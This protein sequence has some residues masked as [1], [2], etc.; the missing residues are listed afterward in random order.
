MSQQSH[1]LDLFERASSARAVAHSLA[2]PRAVKKG[3]ESPFADGK[4]PW[5]RVET[6]S[7][8]AQFDEIQRALAP[9]LRHVAADA[10]V[11]DGDSLAL[12]R[13]LPAHSVSLILDD[14]PYHATKKGNIHGD[15]A[16]DTDQ[17]YLDWMAQYAIE[18]RR[19]LK[20]NG[21]LFCFCDSSMAARLEVLFSSHFNV[22]SHVVWTK[23]N[24]PGFDGWKG[25]MK[26]EALRQWYPHSERIL[27]AEPAVDGNLGRSPFAQFLREVRLQSG[28]SQHLLTE[29]IGAYGKVNHGG[30]VSNWETGRNTPSREQ[31]ERMCAAFI[32]TG[33]I[34]FE[35][36]QY[37]DAV[38]VFNMDASKEFTDIWTF[39]SVRPYKGKHPAEKPAALLEHAIEA[40][41]RPGDIVLDCHAGSG[42]TAIAALALKRRT[43]AMEIDPRWASSIAKWIHALKR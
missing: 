40:T 8:E 18:W 14:P 15:T 36:P 28:L 9:H 22:L 3:A 17:Q 33:N 34:D 1:D 32:G 20:T 6:G 2:A 38:R 7:R 39:P 29:L 19:V 24:D 12:L 30:A 16:F 27:F 35:L 37:E 42:S 10:L 13:R 21:S 11:A 43:I 26:K 25:K 4:L 23:P 5:Y 41:T 31:Y